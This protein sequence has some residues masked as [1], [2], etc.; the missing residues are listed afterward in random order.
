[1]NCDPGCNWVTEL[2]KRVNEF[3][4]AEQEELYTLFDDKN[5]PE[6]KSFLLPHQTIKISWCR[7]LQQKKNGQAS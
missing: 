6:K 1:M 4:S 3:D 5:K 7:L 2:T